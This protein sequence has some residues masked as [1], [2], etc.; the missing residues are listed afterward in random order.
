MLELQL[1]AYLDP[2][3]SARPISGHYGISTDAF[4]EASKHSSCVW[5]GGLFQWTTFNFPG[6]YHPRWPTGT[7]YRQMAS[8]MAV[9]W[10]TNSAR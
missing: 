7:T 6:Q 4:F 5:A 9:G 8:T 10:Y 3:T 1:K 2:T